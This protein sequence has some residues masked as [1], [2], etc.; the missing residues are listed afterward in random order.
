MPALLTFLVLL[1]LVL[2]ASHANAFTSLSSVA[3]SEVR[4]NH[5]TRL[6]QPMSDSTNEPSC[7]PICEPTKRMDL[8]DVLPN[9]LSSKKT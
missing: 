5:L 4:V 2:S 7:K 6:Q 3:E 1:A 9:D 8:D